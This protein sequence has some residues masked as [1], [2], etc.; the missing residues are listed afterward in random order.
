MGQAEISEQEELEMHTIKC[1]HC[2]GTHGSVDQVRI[3]SEL[4][5]VSFID[6]SST[7]VNTTQVMDAFGYG[8]DTHTFIPTPPA[9]AQLIADA[10]SAPVT[11]PGMYRKPNGVIFRVKWN[12]EKTHLY[13]QRL[14]ENDYY[15][16]KLSFEFAPGVMKEL[17]M[18]MRMSLEEAKEYGKKIGS[19]CVCGRTLTAAT[20]I[21]AGIGPIC[22]GGV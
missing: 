10:S 22:M 20:S 11:E 16:K 6:T 18:G 17:T 21:E 8:V 7:G 14:K 19:C 12:K 2:K 1:G 9:L 15:G 3:C 5:N 4:K 13:G